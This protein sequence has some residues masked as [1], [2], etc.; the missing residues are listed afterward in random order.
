MAWRQPSQRIQELI[1]RGAWI[2]LNPSREWLEE[3][4]RATLSAFP[5]ISDDPGLAAV[6]TRSN[7]ANL[8]YFASALLRTPGAPVAPN[9]SSET[10]RMARDLVRR[11]LDVS[12]LEVYRVGHNVAW[13]RW[14]EIAFELT[15]DPQELRELLDL[16]F[17]SANEFVDGT[18]AGITA[19]MQAEYDA[20]T[21]DVNVE[22]R[23]IVD[24]VLERAAIKPERA[25]A[26]LN[27]LFD[28]SHTAAII[29]SAE[30]DD[31]STRLDEVVNAY[32]QAVFKDA[33]AKPHPLIVLA[34]VSTRWVWVGDAAPVDAERIRAIVQ[35]APDVR[36]AIGGPAAGID[37]FR[38][39]HREALTTQRMVARLRST[40]QVAIF[41]EV[42]MVALL[43]ENPI[44]ANEFIRATLGDFESASPALH[45]T[46]LTYLTAASNASR[47]AKLLYTHRNTL[48]H[49]LDAA[50]RLL[51]RPLE[52]SALEVAIALKAL[53]W[54]GPQSGDYSD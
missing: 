25:E 4:D 50:Q 48:L 45:N 53:P 32:I 7:R 17:R 20:L 42:E 36:I 22:R 3:F 38:R 6:V 28:P 8:V 18:L 47:A 51:P 52:E 12:A 41:A 10:L 24:L 9:L 43:T 49:R 54:R 33:A 5:P 29:W 26:Q 13:R 40:Q 23:R 21:Q 30:S 37:G 34:G 2:A 44:G 16:A 15:A 11:G 35:D 19:Q 1:R 39:S 31:D 27:Y 14:I 46:V